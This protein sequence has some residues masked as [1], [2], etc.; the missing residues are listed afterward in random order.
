MI[1]IG[2]VTFKSENVIFDFDTRIKKTPTR[3][4]K[5]KEDKIGKLII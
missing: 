4:N 1:Y 3:G 5:I 2:L